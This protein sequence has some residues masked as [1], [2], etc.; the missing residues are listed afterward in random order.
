[1]RGWSIA[2]VLPRQQHQRL[3]QVSPPVFETVAVQARRGRDRGRHR[4]GPTHG[5]IIALVHG[6]DIDPS[7]PPTGSSPKTLGEV[8]MVK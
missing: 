8:I 4:L 1:M 2:V 5:V 7:T 6:S 3:G